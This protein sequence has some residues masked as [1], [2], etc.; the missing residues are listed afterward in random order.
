MIWLEKLILTTAGTYNLENLRMGNDFIADIISIYDEL[1][2]PQSEI[3]QEIQGNLE[4]LFSNWQ[5]QNYLEKLSKDELLQL[6]IEAR[7]LTLDKL[8]RTE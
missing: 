5:G 6:A 2:D 7:G 1:E 8:I 4:I 3:W